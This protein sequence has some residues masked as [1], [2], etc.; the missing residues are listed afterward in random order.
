MLALV[1]QASPASADGVADLRARFRQEKSELLAHF[2]AARASGP[3]ASRLIRALTR[4]VDRTL[5]AIWDACGMPPGAALVA[6]GGYG[7]GELF[8]HSDVDVLVL[9]PHAAE[10][11]ESAARDAIERFVARCWDTGLEIGS[12]VRSISECV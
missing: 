1:D 12:A 2:L 9:L 11:D 10:S 8:P 4:L 7:R 3:A 5:H 6:V